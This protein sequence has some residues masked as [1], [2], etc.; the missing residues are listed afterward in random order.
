MNTRFLLLMMTLLAMLVGCKKDD[1]MRVQP[2]SFRLAVQASEGEFTFPTEKASIRI[3]NRSTTNSYEA[4]AGVDGTA[5]FESLTPGSYDVSVSLLVT[6]ASYTAITGIYTEEDVTFNGAMERVELQAD[7]E[8]SIDL[9]IGRVGGW[10]FKQIYYVGSHVT[11]GAAFRDVFFEIY[12]NSNELM[13]ADSLFFGQAEGKNSNA[14]NDYV[15]SNFQYDWSKSLEIAVGAGLNANNDYIYANSIFMIPSDG[16][17]KKYPVQPGSSIIIA[18]NAVD[19]S[20][21]YALADGVNQSI[22]DPTLTVNLSGADFETYLA[23]YLDGTPY[24]YDI[25][26][27]NVPNVEVVYFVSGNDMV[28]DANGRDA[29][30]LFKADQQLTKVTELP[31]F[32]LPT[33]REIT[34]TT[35]KFKQIPVSYIEDAVEVQNPVESSRV[36]KRL[37]TVLDAVRTHVPAGRYSSQSLV[38]KTLKTVNGR[39]ILK[40]TNN[41]SEDFGY[42]PKADPSKSAT[43]FID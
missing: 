14:T 23:D 27:V 34:A 1:D 2:V 28:L 32:A 25:D 35:N 17:G 30:F 3:T 6:A 24:K 11:R 12:N 18:A 40:D 9:V 39:R 33:V 38:R 4:A 20:G 13:Y 8:S 5:V 10:L 43:S 19:H 26:N 16:T 36:P 31:N 42:L 7:T 22:T 15:L 29:Y 37:P 21:S 41:S